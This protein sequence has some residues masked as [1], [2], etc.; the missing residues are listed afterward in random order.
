MKQV[1]GRIDAACAGGVRPRVCVLC[2]LCVV[3]HL[4][5]AESHGVRAGAAGSGGAG[6]G[7]VP[8]QPAAKQGPALQEGEDRDSRDERTWGGGHVDVQITRSDW[9]VSKKLIDHS[10]S[11]PPSASQRR[12]MCCV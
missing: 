7:D 2:V 4:S 5:G 6:S 1:R 3:C 10:N 9:E 12:H 11:G 8:S